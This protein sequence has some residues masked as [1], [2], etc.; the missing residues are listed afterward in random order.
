MPKTGNKG[1][2]RSVDDDELDR[3]AGRIVAKLAAILQPLIQPVRGPDYR[4]SQ[5]ALE[6]RRAAS[7]AAREKRLNPPPKRR[8]KIPVPNP[9]P[10]TTATSASS[11][12]PAPKKTGKLS[13]DSSTAPTNGTF[14]AYAAAYKLRYGTFPV[15]NAKVNGML[16]K[17]LQR[18]ATDEA[19]MIAAYYVASESPLYVRAKHCVDLL[20]RDAEGVRMEWVT[21][22]KD[23]QRINGS[24]V[25]TVSK[26]WWE[27]WPELEAQGDEL[28]IERGDN[29]T[30]Y[31]FEVLRAAFVA[32]RLPEDVATQLGV[33]RALRPDDPF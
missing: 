22:R 31:R 4:L 16:S 33:H 26:P 24:H 3:L 14:I 6:Q 9:D 29:P 18:V 23:V 25:T 21:G 7:L 30:I 20:L 17:F 19:P 12:I 1:D 10:E 27:V 15:R 13:T 8:K 11:E 2:P 28:G 5:Q 32:G